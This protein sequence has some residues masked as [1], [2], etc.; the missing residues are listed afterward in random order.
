MP[1]YL[2]PGGESP[3]HLALLHINQIKLRALVSDLHK[4]WNLWLPLQIL[5]KLVCLEVSLSLTESNSQRKITI[6]SRHF[7]LFLSLDIQ[8]YNNNIN[9]EKAL[10]PFMDFKYNCNE[11]FLL[12]CLNLYINYQ[13]IGYFMFSFYKKLSFSFNSNYRKQVVTTLMGNMSTEKS[14]DNVLEHMWSGST[15]HSQQRILGAHSSALHREYFASP[16]G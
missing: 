16:S 8:S 12:Y 9:L 6:F 11:L 3:Y 5:R 7:T 15:S 13:N 10:F 1:L 4:A 2:S 14:V